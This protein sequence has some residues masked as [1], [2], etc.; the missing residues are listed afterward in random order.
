M[1]SVCVAMFLPTGYTVTDSR[2]LRLDRGNCTGKTGGRDENGGGRESLSQDSR[3][4]TGRSR[5]SSRRRRRRNP[6]CRPAPPP[7]TRAPSAPAIRGGGRSGGACEVSAAQRVHVLFR[8][9]PR[10]KAQA[11]PAERVGDAARIQRPPPAQPVLRTHAWRPRPR[12]RPILAHLGSLC[13]SPTNAC[14]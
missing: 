7:S 2:A 6:R 14:L 8:P 10:G 12:R 5:G 9:F 13:R 3:W 11:A 4:H 1:P